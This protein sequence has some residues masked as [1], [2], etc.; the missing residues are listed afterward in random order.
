M[1]TPDEHNSCLQFCLLRKSE[2]MWQ[3]R[4]PVLL[5]TTNFFFIIFF[6]RLLTHSA[7][8]SLGQLNCSNVAKGAT[9]VVLCHQVTGFQLW[10]QGQQTLCLATFCNFFRSAKQLHAARAALSFYIRCVDINKLKYKRENCHQTTMSAQGAA[11]HSTRS[12]ARC[13]IRHICSKQNMC[14]STQ[15]V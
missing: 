10:P 9:V 15:A 1:S 12:V 8:T 11:A 2:K 14:K 6:F 4:D 5:A 3:P 13:F 7:H